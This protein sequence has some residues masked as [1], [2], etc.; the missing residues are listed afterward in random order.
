MDLQEAKRIIENRGYKLAKTNSIDEAI[1]LRAAKRIAENAGYKVVNEKENTDNT[2]YGI[3]VYYN[4]DGSFPDIGRQKPEETL[5]YTFDE[6]VRELGSQCA[7]DIVMV[8]SYDTGNNTYYKLDYIEYEN[9]DKLDASKID[10]DDID[11]SCCGGK[12]KGKKKGKKSDFVPFWAKKKKINER[13]GFTDGTTFT[14]ICEKYLKDDYITTLVKEIGLEAAKEEFLADVREYI[15][16]GI[17]ETYYRTFAARIRNQ[18]LFAMIYSISNAM[19][20]GQGNDLNA[21]TPRSAAARRNRRG[22]NAARNRW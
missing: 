21:G 5:R 16:H 22:P 14:G 11:E 8:G 1:K 12:K 20:A 7:D 2:I 15:G 18:S 10:F 9:G 17:S 3:D 19:H 6:M 4:T 13:F